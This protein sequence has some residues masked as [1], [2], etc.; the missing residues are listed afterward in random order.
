MTR[1]AAA[2][3]FAALLFAGAPGIRAEGLSFWSDVPPEELSLSIVDEMEDDEL[4]A[5]I[6]MFGW[7][8]AEPSDLLKRWV[9]RG[10]GSVKVFGWNTDSARLV[11]ISISSLQEIASR[12]RFKIPLF[13]ATDQEGGVIRHVKG[14]TTI[15]PGSMAVGASGY[16]A[17]A[18]LSGYYISREIKALGI[19]M[20]FA[21]SVDLFTNRASTIIG[22]RSFGDSAESAGALGAAFAE[23]SVAAGVLPTAKHFPGHGD[24]AVDSHIA[25]PVI[26]I[27]EKTF[28]ERELLP[29]K[30]LARK[31]VSAIMS[32]HLSFPR[33]DPSGAPASLSKYF[34]TDLLRGELGFDGLV[35]TDDM[36]MNGDTL[37]A[38][39]LTAAF[40]MAIEAG[41]D[42]IIS[43]TTARLDE[44][45]W[46]A[47][48]ER[49]RTNPDFRARVK[50]A[51]R[52]VVKAKID[53]F[54]S[55]NAAP[56]HPNPDTV[57]DF[58]PDKEGEKFFLAQ[59]CRSVTALKGDGVPL[60]PETAGRV[61]LAGSL[62]EFFARGEERYKNSG[63]FKFS[64]AP[65]PNETKYMADH[66]ARIAAG[67]DS[68]ICLVANEESRAIAMALKGCGA[69]VAVMSIM[70][71][72]SARGFGWADAVIAGYSW[73]D[74]TLDAMFGAL[75]G[76]FAPQG[77]LPYGP[78]PS[79]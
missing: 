10:L 51:A 20:N 57:G 77:R 66:I 31:E 27:D 67:Y 16:P 58:I 7:A 34:L 75:A 35:I 9:E 43:S 45:L 55:G 39:S 46:S 64:F 42:I 5:Q 17:D 41:N 68:A 60:E 49:M 13:V 12:G 53:Y 38:G 14:E 44:P 24:T 37:Y 32:G 54:K 52:R 22:P 15:T 29:F 74:F 48:L 6:F 65:G 8:G 4:L 30:T 73:S 56:L 62:P 21:P 63:R 72:E 40:R 70:S 71:P 78:P 79:P 28:R 26:D 18:W 33:V 11:A 25:L 59:A 69:R 36:M 3:A 61:L 2:L 19:N 23:G 76:E 1:K 50:D 47:N